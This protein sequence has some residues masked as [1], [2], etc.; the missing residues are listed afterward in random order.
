MAENAAVAAAAAQ[1]ATPTTGESS[2]AA[3]VTTEANTETGASQE[4]TTETP[5]RRDAWRERY[6][7]RYAPDA[8]E[9]DTDGDDY[10]NNLLGMADEYDRMEGNERQMNDLLASN[11]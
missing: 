4:A 8:E 2:A 6:K 10:Y 9:I 7:K 5:S 3:P 1:A 11:P